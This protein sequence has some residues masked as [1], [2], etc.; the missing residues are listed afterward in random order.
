M[1]KSFSVFM[2]LLVLGAVC[3]S[4]QQE[5]KWAYSITPYA[6]GMGLDGDV[7]VG[8]VTAPVDVDFVDA[9]K[10]LDLAGM[11]AAEANNG[12]WGVL[13]D[14][15]YINLSSDV[16]SGAHGADVELEQWLVRAAALYRLCA[17]E[18]S[19]FEAGAGVRSLDM[20]TDLTVAS[21]NL[22]ANENWIDPVVMARWYQQFGPKCFGTLSADLGGFGVG[23]ELT[24][25]LTAA[26]GYS[27]T[28]SLAGLLGY[29]YLDY[30]YDDDGFVYDVAQ[31]GLALGLR[32]DL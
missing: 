2:S 18:K 28:E 9:I 16:G 19:V 31:S 26:V 6:W 27:F 29:R 5:G 3:V 23:S 7:G 15:A 14:G 10:D 24:W 11:V 1:L 20:D 17:C 25:Q 21:K 8:P 32:I 22:S 4:A 12:T 13:L 30:D